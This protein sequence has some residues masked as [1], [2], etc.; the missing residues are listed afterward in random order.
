MDGLG[1][2]T[3][4][5]PRG[6]IPMQLAM[7]FDDVYF[8]SF[9]V[10]VFSLIV[11]II[12]FAECKSKR[13]KKLFSERWKYPP[14]IITKMIR[15][16]EKIKKLTYLL[17][18]VAVITLLPLFFSITKGTDECVVQLGWLEIDLLAL[19]VVIY[20]LSYWFKA[21]ANAIPTSDKHPLTTEYV[22]K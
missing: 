3:R 6:V 17:F 1:D 18:F 16:S 4:N 7:W 15:T 11:S 10:A 19:T 2:I 9:V 22:K 21:I 14:D 5:Y 13:F 20:A 12:L 8:I